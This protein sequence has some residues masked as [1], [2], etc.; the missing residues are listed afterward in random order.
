MG[1]KPTPDA[2][3]SDERERFFEGLP[4]PEVKTMMKDGIHRYMIKM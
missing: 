4:T 2:S 1:S 3:I